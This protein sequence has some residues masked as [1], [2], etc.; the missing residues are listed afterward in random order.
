[1]EGREHGEIEVREREE[2]AKRLQVGAGKEGAQAKGEQEERSRP[3]N[4]ESTRGKHTPIVEVRAIA[5]N[6]LLRR[7]ATNGSA[8]HKTAS[9]LAQAVARAVGG[10]S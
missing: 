3:M 6:K 9:L 5:T 7:K 1:M 4:K 8:R 2:E 10:Y